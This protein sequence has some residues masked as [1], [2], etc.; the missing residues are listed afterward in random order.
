[1]FKVGYTVSKWHEK[2]KYTV[3]FYLKYYEKG[4]RYAQKMIMVAVI[5]QNVP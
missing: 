5:L 2:E 4:N 1:M 3:I